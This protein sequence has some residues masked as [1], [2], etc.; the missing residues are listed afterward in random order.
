MNVASSTVESRESRPAV[1]PSRTAGVLVLLAA[2]GGWSYWPTLVDLVGVWWNDSDY[3]MGLLVPL[4]AA[5]LAW[6]RRRQLAELRRPAWGWGLAALAAS[7][8]V[9]LAGVVYH[10]GTLERW[11]MLLAVAAVVLLLGGGAVLWNLRW[12]L[13][14]CML[15]FPLPHRVHESVSGPLQGLAASGAVF[16]LEV[17]G[18][19]VRREGNVIILNESYAVAVAEAC[20]GLRMLMAFVVVAAVFAFMVRRPAW[21]KG[22]LVVSSAPIAILCNLARLVASAQLMAAARSDLAEHLMHDM[23]GYVMM[24]LAVGILALELV[25]LDWLAK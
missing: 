6:S 22:A 5:G 21:K 19:A 8:A 16:L 2:A 17:F 23:A 20:S 3:S 12:I 1:G 24:P 4:V 15:M 13:L 11:S 14:F 25:V 10:Y 9:R 7:Q 18:A